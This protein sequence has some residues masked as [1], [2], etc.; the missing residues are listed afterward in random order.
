MPAKLSFQQSGPSTD[1]A[2]ALTEKTFR[3]RCRLW[4]TSSAWER[5]ELFLLP[6]RL[7]GYIWGDVHYC[8]EWQPGTCG[9][10]ADHQRLDPDAEEGNRRFGVVRT[11]LGG[12]SWRV[13]ISDGQRQLLAGT[14]KGLPLTTVRQPQTQDWGKVSVLLAMHTSFIIRLLTELTDESLKLSAILSRKRTNLLRRV[15]QLWLG[16]IFNVFRLF[17]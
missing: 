3:S 7:S 15:V 17:M 2:A 12:V 14:G 16:D 13:W 4:K 6:V 5:L 9:A 10:A 1:F 11:E 8:S